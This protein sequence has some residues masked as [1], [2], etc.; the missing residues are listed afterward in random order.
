M[1][2]KREWALYFIFVLSVL[3]IGLSIPSL[4]EHFLAQRL[5]QSKLEGFYYAANERS[6]A[7]RH[8]MKNEIT[9]I[10]F[11]CGKHDVQILRDLNLYNSQ[12]RVQGIELKDG[13]GCS[14]LGSDLS[15]LSPSEPKTYAYKFYGY[16][17]GFTTTHDI[18]NTG[19]EVVT[20]INVNGNF[21]YWVL[22]SAWTHE[23]LQ[24]PCKNCFYIEYLN[25]ASAETTL[26]SPKGNLDIKNRPEGEVLVSSISNGKVVYKLLAGKELVAYANGKL[27]LY[28]A[29][30]MLVALSAGTFIFW[31]LTHHQSS[32][33]ELL[34]YGLQKNEFFPYYQPI[35]N[36][37][38]GQV[39]G[40]E[41]LL[42]WYHK[43]EMISPGGFIE[44]AEQHGMILDITEQVIEK[45]IADLSL[46]PE[47]LWV[48]VNIVPEQIE[49]G[50]LF[51]MLKK[52]RWHYNSKLR[53]EITERMRVSDFAVAAEEISKVKTLGYRFKLDDFGTGY[54]G[55]SYIQKLGVDEIKIDKMFV[56]TIGTNDVKKGV[57]DSIIAFAK[58]AGMDPVAEGVET[59]AQVDYLVSKGIYNI[60]G[61]FYSR[62][63]PA[64]AFTRWV[65]EYQARQN[66]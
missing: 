23:Q 44:H 18:T 26:F 61:F 22:N 47:S 25:I 27:W 36:A 13:G 15:I 10:Q 4:F 1:K 42:R 60:Q 51:R 46:F 65:A 55:F 11:D 38:T 52:H 3:G 33:S 62:P 16:D 56:D 9:N 34:R 5:L 35:V 7:I 29:L 20:F 48:S 30:F 12:F 32:M 50:S 28:A 8:V 43:G 31:I 17:V 39:I 14:S 19:G 37:K 53:F 54:G 66:S 45:I 59:Q 49:N 58:E 40:A 41:A 6:D 2:I 63:L 24:S 64:Y 21:I 57:L